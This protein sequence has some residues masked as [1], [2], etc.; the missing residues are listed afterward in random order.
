MYTSNP[1]HFGKQNQTH[2]HPPSLLP[3]FTFTIAKL[4]EKRLLCQQ[5]AGLFSPDKQFPL[6]LFILPGDSS[7]QL[8]GQ[9][10]ELIHPLSG[11]EVISKQ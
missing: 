11:L 7:K 4:L 2:K 10:F 5:D 1:C 6:F 8:Q 9:D 3:P